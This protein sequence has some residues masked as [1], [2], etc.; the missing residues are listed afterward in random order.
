M[1]VKEA[2]KLIENIDNEVNNLQKLCSL[3]DVEK[4]SLADKCSIN[5]TIDNMVLVAVNSMLSWK[6]GLQDRI[7]NAEVK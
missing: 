5:N 7:D 2:R 3:D 6:S 4:E 1:K